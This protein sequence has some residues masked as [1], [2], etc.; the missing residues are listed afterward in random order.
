MTQA[1]VISTPPLV[2]GIGEA[3]YD[4]IDGRHLLGGAPVNFAVHAHQM[5]QPAGGC[6]VVASRVG[7][8]DLGDQLLRELAQRQMDVAWIQRDGSAPTGLVTVSIDAAGHPTYT[9]N[10]GAAWDCFEFTPAWAELARRC[11]AVCFGSLAQRSSASRDVI[12]SFLAACPQALRIC[13]LNL[14][15]HYFDCDVV[16]H[17][18]AAAT[19]LKLNEEELSVVCDLLEFS[20]SRRS[21]ID[22]CIGELVDRFELSAVALSR[23]ER[24]TVLYCSG[25]KF[26]EPPPRCAAHAEADSVGAGDACCA[27]LAAGLLLRL[28]PDRILHLCNEAGA[29]VASCRGATPQLPPGLTAALVT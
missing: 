17:S 9:I 4:L 1:F 28:S 21:S 24:G 16:R 5:L 14:R 13:D 6:A 27:A 2:V 15:Q 19:V 23:G 10:P 25:A 26:E 7:C 18:L 22:D 29:Y 11:S 8:D 20:P 12:R 3:L